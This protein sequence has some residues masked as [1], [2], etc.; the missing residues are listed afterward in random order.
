[1]KNL[2]LIFGLLLAFGANAGVDH[3]VKKGIFNVECKHKWDIGR[4]GYSIA[5]NKVSVENG[6]LKYTANFFR[7]L[8]KKQAN[9]TVK[10]ELTAIPSTWSL[11]T[12]NCHRGWFDLPTYFGSNTHKANSKIGASSFSIALD[13]E[14]MKNRQ[15]DK[16]KDGKS[17]KLKLTLHLSK[18]PSKKQYTNQRS[19]GYW[20]LKLKFTP[21]KDG[22]I[23]VQ[24]IH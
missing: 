2:M 23:L 20:D 8:C 3:S 19:K 9:G 12:V 15:Y 5:I 24:R 1:M 7:K 13:E 17:F 10:F 14:L 21:Q 22:E 18:D 11:V 6:E 4:E 16:M